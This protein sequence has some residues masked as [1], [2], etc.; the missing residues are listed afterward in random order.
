MTKYE[1]PEGRCFLVVGRCAE[2]E[3]VDVGLEPIPRPLP[4]GKDGTF[5]SRIVL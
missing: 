3:V 2:A 5:S 1:V 4:K